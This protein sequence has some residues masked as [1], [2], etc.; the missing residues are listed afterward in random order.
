MSTTD[1]INE[2]IRRVEQARMAVHVH[3]LIDQINADRTDAER[4]ARGEN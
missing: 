1:E 3:N 4:F 2:A